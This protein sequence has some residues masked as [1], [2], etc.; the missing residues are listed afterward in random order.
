MYFSYLSRN[1][2]IIWNSDIL[3]YIILQVFII[4]III[5]LYIFYLYWLDAKALSIN[6]CRC[7][8]RCHTKVVQNSLRR[9]SN[10][11][12]EHDYVG[13]SFQNLWITHGR[14][15]YKSCCRKLPSSAIL[16]AFY[17]IPNL[18]K[19]LWSVFERRSPSWVI[20]L[21]ELCEYVNATKTLPIHFLRDCPV[22]LKLALRDYVTFRRKTLSLRS[23][24]STPL[25]DCRRHGWRQRFF[26][27]KAPVM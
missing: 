17:L 11:T 6:K 5:I 25:H 16:K 12:L 4:I 14:S 22:P 1:N 13:D 27:Y 3:L 7:R 15:V 20:V 23:S 26:E 24:F 9:I 10:R 18:H 19:V 21:V 2:F 8:C